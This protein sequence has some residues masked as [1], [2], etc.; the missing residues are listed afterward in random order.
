MHDRL[1]PANHVCIIIYHIGRYNIIMIS[2]ILCMSCIVIIL[3]LAIY[4][5]TV[6]EIRDDISRILL[7]L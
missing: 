5:C 1:I 3:K 7:L 6:D 4:F 2:T